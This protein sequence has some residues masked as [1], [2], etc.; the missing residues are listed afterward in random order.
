[1]SPVKLRNLGIPR[2]QPEDRKGRFRAR[3]HG[4]VNYSGWWDTKGNHTYTSIHLPIQHRS[5][6]RG[7]EGYESSSSAPQTPHRHILMEH[8]QNVVQY[9]FT[10]GKT[11]RKLPE[12]MSQI[13]ILQKTLLITKGWNP[14]RRFK[15]LEEREARIRET[16]ATIQTIEEQLHQAEHALFPSR[17]QGVNQ[18][19]FPLDSHHSGIKSHH[20]SHCHVH[21][22]RKQRSKRE[23]IT[24]LNQRQK[25][26]DPMIQKL[27][28]L[29]KEV[30][31]SQE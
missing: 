23:N 30:H 25:E 20:S 29:L 7:L 1:M 6:T 13:D 5:Q 31:K 11:W 12:D 16:Q 17:S 2:N 4:S 27:L 3:R 21:A 10:L 18:P 8:G 14:N 15:I 9:S 24:S 26:S 22:R 19:D 28:D